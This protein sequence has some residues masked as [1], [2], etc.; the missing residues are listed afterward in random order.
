LVVADSGTLVATGQLIPMMA[1]DGFHYGATIAQPHPGTYRL[2]Y[3]IHPPSALPAGAGGMGRHSDPATGIA[4]WWEPFEASFDWTVE[5][6]D[7]KVTS[8]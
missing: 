8:R 3:A 7:A 5:L 1:R 6:D 4:P 2:I